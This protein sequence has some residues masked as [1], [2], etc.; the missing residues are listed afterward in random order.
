MHYD[1][2]VINTRYD[3]ALTEIGTQVCVCVCV[4]DEQVISRIVKTEHL[5][6]GC[7]QDLKLDYINPQQN[8]IKRSTKDERGHSLFVKSKHE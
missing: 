2:T 7:I 4:C 3:Q 1:F 8:K 6:N 5:F